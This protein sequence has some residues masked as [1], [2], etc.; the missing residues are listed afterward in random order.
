MYLTAI[1]LTFLHFV[2]DYVII[3][4]Q[5]EDVL[6]EHSSTCCSM[7]IAPHSAYSTYD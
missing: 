5:Q 1:R 3:I 4:L 6:L 2:E 7:Y